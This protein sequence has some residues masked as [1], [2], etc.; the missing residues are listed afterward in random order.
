MDIQYRMVWRSVLLATLHTCERELRKHQAFLVSPA[1]VSEGA[2]W[3]G[4]GPW[5]AVADAG[6]WIPLYRLQGA[7]G[8]N[9]SVL[10][11]CRGQTGGHQRSGP[12][13]GEVTTRSSA[14]HIPY[15]ISNPSR[16]HRHQR[17]LSRGHTRLWACCNG[18]DM[19]C[20]VFLKT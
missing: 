14:T 16:S 19:K 2:L 12:A 7:G 15:C 6:R 18:R 5:A 8:R 10:Q 11:G 4:R 13:W 3:L 17:P 1:G 9:G 20:S